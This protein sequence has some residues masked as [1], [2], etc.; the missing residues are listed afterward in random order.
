MVLVGLFDDIA[1]H[2]HVL[3]DEVGAVQRVSHDATHES[4]GEHDCVGLLLIKEFLY[5]ELVS[6]VQFFMRTANKIIVATLL[7]VVP[8]G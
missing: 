8:N 5:S 6:K 7:Q 2:L 3:H 1:L 4:C